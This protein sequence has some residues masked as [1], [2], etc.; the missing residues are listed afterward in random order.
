MTN[1]EKVNDFLTQAGTFY[2][3]TIDGDKPKCRPMGFHLLADNKLYFGVGDFKAVYQQIQKNPTVEFCATVE[4][5]FLRYYGQVVF[6]TDDTIANKALDDAPYLRSIYNEE[7]GYKLAI[8][9]L[10]KAVAEFRDMTG[11]KESFVFD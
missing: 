8:F 5:D 10:E 3:A 9:H 7:T 4:N 6:E 1:L 2:L 11:V